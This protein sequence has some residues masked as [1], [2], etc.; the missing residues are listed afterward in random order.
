[1]SWTLVFE[2]NEMKV[3]RQI[4][5]GES[6]IDFRAQ[7]VIMMLAGE[8]GWGVAITN[9]FLKFRKVIEFE[10]SCILICVSYIYLIIDPKK[11]FN[12]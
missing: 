12:N 3:T 8:G 5:K 10:S 7:C 1:M 4:C 6:Y 2:M 9:D 11:S